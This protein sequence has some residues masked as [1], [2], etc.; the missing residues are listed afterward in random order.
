MFEAAPGTDTGNEQERRAALLLR[1][2]PS[3]LALFVI[4]LGSII[5]AI[6]LAKGVQ[7]PDFFWHVTTGE[8]IASS[9]SVPSTDP[10]SFTW[11]GQPWTLHE[12]L[13]EL[14]IYE[15][16][17][18]A[19]DA[20][21][22][23]VFGLL[24]V[25]IFAVMAFVLGRQ[26]VGVLAF[27]LAAL[28]VALVLVPYLTIRPQAI[29]WLMLAT[30][31]GILLGLRP[32][33]P[34]WALVLIPFFALW[35]NLHGL[36]VVGLGVVAAYA[37]F[38]LAGRTPMSAAKGWMAAGSVG[39][40]AAT[41]LTPAGIQGIVYP[42]R[43]VN[44]GDWGLANIRE[45]Q[46]PNFHDPAQLALLGLIVLVA[47]NGGR[48]TPGWLTLLSWVGVVMSLL[49]VRN[50]P[51]A[52]ILALPTL[53]L[54]AQDRLSRLRR[55]PSGE[56]R[57]SRRLM[58]RVMEGILTVVV[59]IAALAITL[60]R[61]PG[62]APD[63]TRSPVA[64]VDRLVGLQ[65]AARTLAEYGWGGYVI[66]RLYPAGGRVFVDGR[67]DM[68]DDSI[69]EAYSAIR[70]AAG[71]WEAQLERYDVEAILLPPSAPLVRGAAQDAGWCEAYRDG[72]Q[73]LLLREGCAP[74]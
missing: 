18:R 42:L 64:G 26:G 25:A 12:W 27:G 20:A 36:W 31:I 40:I 53:A 63:P 29:S 73:V 34:A 67:N 37:I 68:Y 14:V 61:S 47:L 21:T 55:R 10:F 54:G 19:G 41:A 28:P 44:A 7:D 66:S 2:L 17:A 11:A 30:L 1:W 70:A 49:A 5:V 65:P 33:R 9:G 56:R 62:L 58:R 60:P 6:T 59:V 3:P 50:A 74:D 22:L 35:A 45:W 57:P 8:L 16:L 24:P 43:Y 32:T 13:S 39:A 51:V 69:L 23:S 52:A 4:A 46:S 38:T 72:V 71:D 15:L 48:A